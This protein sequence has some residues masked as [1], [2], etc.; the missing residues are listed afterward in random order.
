VATNPN[1]SI[2]R[3]TLIVFLLSHSA[4][5]L[6]TDARKQRTS[7]PFTAKEVCETERS[8]YSGGLSGCPDFSCHLGDEVLLLVLEGTV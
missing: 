1:P 3:R 2:D 6:E 5:I 7:H 4:E 8:M